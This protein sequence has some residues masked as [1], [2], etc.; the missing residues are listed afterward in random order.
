M[1]STT[2]SKGQPLPGTTPPSAPTIESAVAGHP[3]L[4]G[5]N[6]H[7]LRIVGGLAIQA[8]WKAG[9]I[10]LREGDPANRFYLI[11]S[12]KVA[13]ESY[14]PGQ[15]SR[16]IEIIGPG[17][18]VGWSWLFPPYSWHFSVRALE[19]TD[20]IFVYGTPLREECERDHE[21]GYELMKRMAEVML[22]R[23][24]SARWQLLGFA[25]LPITSVS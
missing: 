6:A 22:K 10:I 24:R 12:G 4:R 11:Q 17:E 3:F 13:I 25:D 9:E 5:M 14:V 15:G 19:P 16:R 7:Q 2:Q 1:N 21:L 23:L 20:A 8:H 18:V